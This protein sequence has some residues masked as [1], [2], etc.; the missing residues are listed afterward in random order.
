MT[1]AQV[2]TLLARI[3]ERLGERAIL[4]RGAELGG[5]DVDLLV[6]EDALGELGELLR[7][8]G[9]TPAPGDPGHTVWSG[10]GLPPIDVLAGSAWPAYY[11]SLDGV[12]ARLSPSE[13][14]PPV[15]SAAD[16]ALMLAAEAVA[17]RPL[18]KV[19]GKARPA[20]EAAGTE[21][22]AVAT[23]EGLEGLARLVSRPDEL[24]RRGRRGRLPY[25]AA[26]RLALRSPA[27]RA[28]LAARVRG[29]A[30]RV[31]RRAGRG[32]HRPLLV[33]LSGM[34]GAGKSTA[35]IALTE[36]LTARGLPAEVAWAR[37]GAE[38]ELLDRLA[39]P[40]KRLVRRRGTVADPVAAGGP[41]VEKVQDPRESGGRRRLVSWIWIVI[42]AWATARTYRRTA[43]GRRRGVS[44]VCDRWAT[45]AIVD[46]ELRYGRHRVGEAVLRRLPPRPDLQVLLE[47]DAATSIAR[48]PQ[49]QA[50]RVLVEMERLYAEEA[51]NSGLTR[52][53]ARMPREAVER[54]LVELVEPLI[55][56]SATAAPS[57]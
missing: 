22:D 9:L 36:H 39:K 1:D 6:L 47:L 33:A 32:G 45:D 18:E 3:R 24:L 31:T 52:V 28:A 10:A 29:S 57:P 11:P 48:K 51:R 16:R 4:W 54:R 43:R 53:D 30:G 25:P 23:D 20:V 7:S 46:L 26:L 38:S 55:G 8:G 21:L 34:D 37:L 15:A 40:V 41:A 12:V 35:A 42:V 49:D 44:I 2:E 14:G 5:R 17:G 27:P 50:E 13:A 19:A 56:G